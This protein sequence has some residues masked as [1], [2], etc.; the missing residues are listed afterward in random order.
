MPAET[1]NTTTP[2]HAAAGGDMPPV[3]NSSAYE[4]LVEENAA[5]KRRL[6]EH[7]QASKKRVKRKPN[8][9]QTKWKTVYPLEVARAKSAEATS[10]CV[11]IPGKTETK[12]G[13]PFELKAYSKRYSE[14][15]STAP[16]PKAGEPLEPADRK[17]FMQ[18]V[19][20][21]AKAALLAEAAAKEEEAKQSAAAA[22]AHVVRT[23]A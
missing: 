4:A 15:M 19:S 14:A 20:C 16:N 23:P 12:T 5:L 8:A 6:K 7:E 3:H 18:N 10:T 11:L 1:D 22:D 13:L 17:V 2:T 9:Y 21:R